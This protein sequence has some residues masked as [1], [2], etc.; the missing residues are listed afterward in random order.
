MSNEVTK[1]GEPSWVDWYKMKRDLDA[2]KQKRFEELYQLVYDS[3]FKKPTTNP[4]EGLSKLVST[5]QAAPEHNIE[6]A[7]STCDYSYLTNPDAWYANETPC[8]TDLLH[9]ADDEED[10]EIDLRH[11]R[12]R[13]YLYPTENGEVVTVTIDNPTFLLFDKDGNHIVEDAKY[14][15]ELVPGW[16]AIR[17]EY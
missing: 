8:W 5:P 7:A 3:V 6:A 17:K 4:D 10:K 2:E 16:V 11:E 1:T 13:S 12:S 14:V 9:I 15:Y